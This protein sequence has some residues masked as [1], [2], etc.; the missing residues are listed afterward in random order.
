LITAKPTFQKHQN[1]SKSSHENCQMCKDK[2]KEQKR[3]PLKKEIKRCANR[4][5][6]ICEEIEEC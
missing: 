1:E 5:E 3:R 6:S 2:A 4:T